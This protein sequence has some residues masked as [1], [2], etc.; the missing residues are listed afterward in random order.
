MKFFLH[1]TVVLLMVFFL[2]QIPLYWTDSLNNERRDFK[3]EAS[4][5]VSKSY[6][7]HQSMPGP[8]LVF[9]YVH[10]YWQDLVNNQGNP[11]GREQKFTYGS[12]S[13]LPKKLSIINKMTAEE[14]RIGI[15]P[16]PVFKAEVQMAAD[17]SWEEL[18]SGVLLK[19]DDTLEWGQ[20]FI[21]LP[22]S[23]QHGI[24]VIQKMRWED[25]D[26][27]YTPGSQVELFDG[28]GIHADVPAHSHASNAQ[29]L[30]HMEVVGTE[31]LQ[32]I[33]T[34][35]QTTVTTQSNWPH[36]QFL[37]AQLPDT[38]D[39]SDNG[40]TAVWF[41]SALASN[42]NTLWQKCFNLHDCQSLENENLGV[43]L[44][45]PTNFYT[46]MT[47]ALKYGFLFLAITFIAFLLF[48]VLCNLRIHP[49]QYAFLGI[50]SGI[51]FILLLSFAEHIGFAYAY[52]I[53]AS[54]CLL[55]LSVYA[56]ALLK[57]W[58]RTLSFSAV[59]TMLY[60][61]LYTILQQEDAALLTGSLLIFALLAVAMMS[62]R[63]IDWYVWQEQLAKPTL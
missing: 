31:M 35:D 56:H 53:A 44:I 19:P 60:L 21:A 29:A 51:F 61:V 10:A 17:F 32:N 8:I 57:H 2:V 49:V 25:N 58:R 28:K 20:A 41:S 11:V 52:A 15:F 27:A 4:A 42:I 59:L 50:A 16:V 7:A 5:T 30:I 12:I 23:D 1:K 47:R 24:K 26:L 37:G 9:P 18:D 33:P 54:G 38:R 3:K 6:A 46:K 39:I 13:L 55:L 43:Q 34:A 14:R 45:D 63:K 62:T 48:E 40:F 36:P 22:I